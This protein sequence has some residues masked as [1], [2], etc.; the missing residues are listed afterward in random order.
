MLLFDASYSFLCFGA[1]AGGQ[2]FFSTKIRHF[3]TFFDI[4]FDCPCQKWPR[5]PKNRHAFDMAEGK[6]D[7]HAGSGTLV[8]RTLL[9]VNLQPA[10]TGSAMSSC[11]QKRR[12]KAR[13]WHSAPQ[14]L[15]NGRSKFDMVMA[16][17]DMSSTSN[18]KNPAVGCVVDCAF[19]VVYDLCFPYDLDYAASMAWT[20]GRG[21][22]R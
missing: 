15:R 16:K 8:A 14:N 7:M 19:H 5:R 1:G 12:A 9:L 13:R 21:A 11:C 2:G 4:L 3:H 17:I 22:L 6:L 10:Q 18:I 20:P